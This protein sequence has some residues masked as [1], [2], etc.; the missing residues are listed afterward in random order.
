ML[1]EP[2]CF[3]Q[4]ICLLLCSKLWTEGGFTRVTILLFKTNSSFSTT[5]Y[6]HAQLETTKSRC[7]SDLLTKKNSHLSPTILWQR[8]SIFPEITRYI[9]ACFCISDV[10]FDRSGFPTTSRFISSSSSC[11]NLDDTPPDSFQGA[12]LQHKKSCARIS[13][14]MFNLPIQ[15]DPSLIREVLP[16]YIML[17]MIQGFSRF[18][19]HILPKKRHWNDINTLEKAKIAKSVLFNY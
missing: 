12:S 15:R 8:S 13:F 14:N 6:S 10:T 17:W 2:K 4:K 19:L 9:S 3:K 7:I 1:L 18:I 16:C 5:R 11:F